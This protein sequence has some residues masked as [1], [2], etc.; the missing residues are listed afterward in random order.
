MRISLSWVAAKTLWSRNWNI[1]DFGT[2]C[3]SLPSQILFLILLV[4][5]VG[6]L[7]SPLLYFLELLLLGRLSSSL[8]SRSVNFKYLLIFFSQTVFVIAAHHSLGSMMSFLDDSETATYLLTHLPRPMDGETLCETFQCC[9]K[10][11]TDKFRQ[12]SVK[13]QSV[14]S[15]CNLEC[16]GRLRGCPSIRSWRPSV[17]PRV[18]VT[19]RV[20]SLRDTLCRSRC[21]GFVGVVCPWHVPLE[22]DPKSSAN[23]SCR[24]RGGHASSPQPFPQKFPEIRGYVPFRPDLRV[25]KF[26]Q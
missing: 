3:F 8:L 24:R 9:L 19:T 4:S 18:N 14:S 7:S 15:V 11:L 16:R 12:S 25:W 2:S 13:R 10:S 5:L 1:S 21:Q 6:T 23:L 20:R 17:M 26:I 22:P